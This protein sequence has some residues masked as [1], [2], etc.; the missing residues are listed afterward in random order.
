MASISDYIITSRPEGWSSCLHPVL[1]KIK[2]IDDN[3]IT[4]I[5]TTGGSDATYTLD[6]PPGSMHEI[7]DSI[8]FHFLE[9][10]LT[11]RVLFG[12]IT[13][14]QPSAGPVDR[15]TTDTPALPGTATLPSDKFIN[16]FT[17][18]PGFAFQIGIYDAFTDER[19]FEDDFT[20]TPSAAGLCTA[21]VQIIKDLMRPEIVLADPGDSETDNNRFKYFY[22]KFTPAWIG[23]DETEVD[24]VA[25]KKYTS[26]TG[27]QIRGGMSS[28]IITNAA[29]SW[30]QEIGDIIGGWLTN[31][32]RMRLFAGRYFDI[33]YWTVESTVRF[34]V[35]RYTAG[36]LTSAAIVTAQ[37]YLSRYRI[38]EADGDDEIRISPLRESSVIEPP[39]TD[40]NDLGGPTFPF[41]S[42]TP[43]SLIAEVTSG[44]PSTRAAAQGSVTLSFDVEE[45]EFEYEVDV[46]G[47]IDSGSQFRIIF[48]L[49]N[50]SSQAVYEYQESFSGSDF[51]G[52]LTRTATL[53]KTMVG[54]FE[55]V[56]ALACRFARDSADGSDD[57][58]VEIILPV[59]D[60]ISYEF[61]SAATKIIDVVEPCEPSVHL[62]WMNDKGGQDWWS[63][64]ANQDESQAFND[65]ERAKRLV[66]YDDNLTPSEFRALSGLN[67]IR[68]SYRTAIAEIATDVITNKKRIG[69]QVYDATDEDALRG[70]IVLPRS[71]N[72]RTRHVKAPIVIEIE[73]PDD[74]V[75]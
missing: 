24:D 67:T 32:D 11:D 38:Q 63:F 25:N 52:P 13:D 20:F 40:W 60:V 56:V 1:Y 8:A 7:G 42:K 34:V 59:G 22:I 55:D 47:T 43:T 28:N 72:L 39:D 27:I 73:Y 37:G 53:E 68:Q 49:L 33:A 62:G 58:D 41:E 50:G 12:T 23:S 65:E 35:Q 26:W 31:F 16:N 18:R 2:R 10:G 21:D 15:I 64:Q 6:V 45:V 36:V 4:S 9:N 19:L 44:P 74:S 70:V 46:T 75:Q 54:T 5:G 69:Q 48:Q 66:L 71:N 14:I 17:Q 51:P 29:P 3:N 30:P 57:Y 61:I